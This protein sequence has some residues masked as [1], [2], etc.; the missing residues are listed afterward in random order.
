MRTRAD[1]EKIYEKTRTTDE[2]RRGKFSID[3]PHEETNRF[4]N[5]WMKMGIER[6]LLF[7]TAPRDN[8]QFAH[9]AMMFVP[10]AAKFTIKNVMTQQYRDGHILRRWIRWEYDVFADAPMWHNNNL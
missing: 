10:E 3:T 8:L 6:N 4:I 2:I 1:I 5:P 9:S 7:R